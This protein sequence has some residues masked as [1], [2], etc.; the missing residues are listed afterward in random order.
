MKIKRIKLECIM[1]VYI[2]HTSTRINTPGTM[3]QIMS[4]CKLQPPGYPFV[5]G[6]CNRFVIVFTFKIIFGS[7]VR[8]NLTSGI[9]S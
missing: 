3:I 5:M 1:L 2:N 8:W 7:T 4:A 6:W 9:P